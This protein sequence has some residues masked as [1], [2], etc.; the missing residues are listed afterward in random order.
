MKRRVFGLTGLALALVL[1]SCSQPNGPSTTFT[2][3]LGSSG[4]T[5]LRGDEVT[6]QVDA[7]HATGPVNLSVSGVPSGVTATLANTTLS[8]G[9]TSTTLHVTVTPAATDGNATLSIDAV[10]G[11]KTAS[12]TFDLTISSLSVNGT[13]TDLFGK[14][15]AGATVAIQGTTDTTDS[16]GAFTITGVAVPYDL[17][18][19]QT[20][21]S[22]EV[23]QS[24]EGLTSPTPDVNPYGSIIGG[25]SPA[26]GATISGNLSSA[27]TAGYEALVCAQSS[28][29]WMSGCNA[30][31]AG[32]T[33]YAISVEWLYGT[34]MPVTLYAIEVATDTNG[35]AIGYHRYGTA[36]GNVSN[37]GSPT[38]DVAWSG[39][40]SVA[41]IDTT[42]DVPAGF[43]LQSLKGAADIGPTATLPLF[44]A[45]AGTLPSNFA[46]V[47]PALGAGGHTLFASAASSSGGGQSLAWKHGLSGGSSTTIDLAAPP[48]LVS[49]ADG[50]TGIGVGSTIR[51]DGL[52]GAATYV[53]S[54][55]SRFIVVTTMNPAITIPD[56]TSVGMD[57][58]SGT[59][60]WQALTMPT[61]STP[62]QAAS[63]WI[64][65]YL[66]T[67]SAVVDGGTRGNLSEGAI[68]VTPS[69]TFTVP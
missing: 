55:S 3:S 50:A 35:F 45:V 11:G 9:A 4:D 8:G 34:P 22:A 6:V 5:V 17:I 46:A 52:T 23:A 63:G 29:E 14:G 10:S 21:T 58:P 57:L 15:M 28:V 26:M 19:K 68:T 56:L 1:A 32:N 44:G 12:A 18:V 13:V 36:S 2:V 47:V 60:I 30:V 39:T 59:Y 27:V 37:G 33:S 54:G 42:V 40:P 43:L 69:R 38:I 41:T 48:T 67:N 24:F 61:A 62:E 53:I 65:E 25:S 66:L 20:I 7:N 16:N 64:R 49:P 31:S 51:L